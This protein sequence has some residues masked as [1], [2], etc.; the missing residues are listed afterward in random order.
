MKKIHPPPRTANPFKLRR[1]QDVLASAAAT[2]AN[3]VDVIAGDNADRAIR[4]VRHKLEKALSV[5][6]TVNELITSATD[7]HNLCLIF[8]G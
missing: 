6:Y 5:Q 2:E 7:E 1:A 4:G 8:G 3:P